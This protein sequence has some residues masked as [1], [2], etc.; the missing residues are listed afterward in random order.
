LERPYMERGIFNFN[1]SLRKM[2]YLYSQ[3]FVVIKIIQELC[4]NLQ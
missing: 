2:L 3:K 1:T 4:L